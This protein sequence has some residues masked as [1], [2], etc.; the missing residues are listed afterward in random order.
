MFG[1]VDNAV[2]GANVNAL[3][4]IIM[5]DTFGAFIGIDFINE[6]AE[7]NG[8]VGTCGFTHVAVDTICLNQ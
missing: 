8:L 2:D 3:G 1:V 6:R 7:I 4:I 5:T